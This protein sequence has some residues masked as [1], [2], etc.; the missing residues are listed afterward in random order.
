MGGWHTTR[1]DRVTS[2]SGGLSD[3]AVW[4]LLNVVSHLE[5][6][7][8]TKMDLGFPPVMHPMLCQARV[9]EKSLRF[10]PRGHR[11]GRIA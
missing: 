9:R 2:V 4:E 1:W 7:L 11:D 3:E 5:G 10:S 6:R 8:C